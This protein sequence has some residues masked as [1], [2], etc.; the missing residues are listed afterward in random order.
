MAN[1]KKRVEKVHAPS[2]DKSFLMHPF[3]AIQPATCHLCLGS[4]KRG[5]LG[6]LTNC[7]SLSGTDLHVQFVLSLA[8]GSLPRHLPFTSVLGAGY[9]MNIKRDELGACRFSTASMLPPSLR[10]VMNSPA[11]FHE[12]SISEHIPGRSKNG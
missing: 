7:Q 3:A 2:M 8:R 9:D 5:A 1:Q 11:D 4:M 10:L 6:C 12:G